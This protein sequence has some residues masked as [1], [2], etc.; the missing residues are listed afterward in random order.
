LGEESNHKGEEGRGRGGKGDGGRERG[1]HDLVL[2][3]WLKSWGPQKEWKKA[4]LGRR[5]LGGPSRM[6]QLPGK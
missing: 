4:T 5:R 6:Y 1:E 3:G 2:G